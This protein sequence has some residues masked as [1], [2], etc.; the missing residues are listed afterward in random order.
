MAEKEKFTTLYPNFRP[1]LVTAYAKIAARGFWNGTV[2][3]VLN[4]CCVAPDQLFPRDIQART[5][6]EY[7]QKWIK[8]YFG[9]YNSR[10]SQRTSNAIG[11]IPDSIVDRIISTR[12]PSLG[13]KEV[14][15]IRAAHRLSMSAENILGLFLEEY[16]AEKLLPCGWFC[17]W[18]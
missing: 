15:A 12:L 5:L 4:V 16:L 9:G 10:P 14:A 11:T 3:T 1:Q 13:D 7:V 2:E 18:G 17:C 8:K 6:E